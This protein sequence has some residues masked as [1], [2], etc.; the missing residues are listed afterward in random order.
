MT[1]RIEKSNCNPEPNP[2][3]NELNKSKLQDE[4]D[5]A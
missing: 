5:C 1:N 4:S 3:G 2:I